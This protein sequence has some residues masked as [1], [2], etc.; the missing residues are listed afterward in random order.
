MSL[1]APIS[2]LSRRPALDPKTDLYLWQRMLFFRPWFRDASVMQVGCR[3][4]RYLRYAAAFARESMAWKACPPCNRANA[5][6]PGVDF[7]FSDFIG[8]S[9]D[10]EVIL[11]FETLRKPKTRLRSVDARSGRRESRIVGFAPAR[12]GFDR[13]GAGAL[14]SLDG[15]RV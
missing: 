2:T 10:A 6:H 7:R 9:F 4:G 3:D 5:T 15:R 8:E 11:A 1:N 13:L 12:L 14:L